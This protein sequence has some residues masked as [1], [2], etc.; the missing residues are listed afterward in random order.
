MFFRE[1]FDLYYENYTQRTFV[2][3]CGNCEFSTGGKYGYMSLW[4]IG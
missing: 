1:I 2:S 4:L 3:K